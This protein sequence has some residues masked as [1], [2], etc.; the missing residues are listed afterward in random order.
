MRS[1]EAALPNS[2]HY[3]KPQTIMSSCSNCASTIIS[4]THDRSAK[5]SQQSS[6]SS[7]IN[8]QN[9]RLQPLQIH[10]ARQMDQPSSATIRTPFSA[11]TAPQSAMSHQSAATSQLSASDIA[12]HIHPHH[13][14]APIYYS[15]LADESELWFDWQS[16]CGDG[17]NPS[18][19][20][21]RAMAQ[22]QLT[23]GLKRKSGGRAA[24]SLPR[25]RV[26]FLAGSC[27]IIIT[28][29]SSLT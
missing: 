7:S 24:I 25:A 10:S 27:C 4:N 2:Q 21:A 1:L 3:A 28:R 16:D 14:D 6:L 9:E 15:H 29:S 20:I 8:A 26:M 19:A 5:Q 11:T 18:Y 23:V 22:P 17:W 13:L 12:S